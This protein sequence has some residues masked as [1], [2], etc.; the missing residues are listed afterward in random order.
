MTADLPPFDRCGLLLDLDGTLLDIAPAPDMVAVPNDLPAHLLTLRERMAGALGIISG[1][2]VEQID[3]LLPGVAYAV[4]GEHGGAIRPAP[5]AAIERPA[6]PSVPTA[7]LDRVALLVAAHPGSMLER[8]RRGFVVH[9]RAAPQAGDALHVALR[10]LLT[11]DHRFDLLQAAMAWEVRP[12]GIDKGVA[13]ATLMRRVPF[14][15]RIP[16]FIGDDVTDEDAIRVAVSSGGVGLR[17]DEA[18]ISAAGVRAWLARAAAQA[19]PDWPT[20]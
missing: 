20:L 10:D 11:T 12:A 2:P 7:W 14:A 18:F 19:G 3:A 17:V 9:Y 1:R 16:V 6:L 8:K 15:G 5:A 4:A 13:L